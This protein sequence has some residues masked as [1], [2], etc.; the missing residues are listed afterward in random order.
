MHTTGEQRAALD[1]ADRLTSAPDASRM[2]RMARDYSWT[3]FHTEVRRRGLRAEFEAL[4]AD[5]T[6]S[7][8]DEPW[9]H[10]VS[11]ALGA[12]LLG[13]A[14]SGGEFTVS[15]RDTLM[16]CWRAVMDDCIR[17]RLYLSMTPHLW[18]GLWPLVDAVLAAP[19]TFS[20]SGDTPGVCA[21]RAR[22][23]R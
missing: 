11:D 10:P 19:G 16:A 5:V 2:L 21:R 6:S 7:L 13:P 4:C 8:G 18:E 1:D 15:D 17:S 12:V 3:R 23:R 9:R 14:D 20:S 22:T